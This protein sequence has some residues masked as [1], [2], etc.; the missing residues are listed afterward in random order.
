MPQ[1]LLIHISDREK[2]P[3]A[4]R[5]VQSLVESAPLEQLQVVIV[6]DI[7]AGGVCLTCHRTLRE[8]MEALV[9]A[10]HQIRVCAT[11]LQALNLRTAGLPEFVST[12]PNSLAEIPAR[13]AEGFQYLKL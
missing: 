1:K 10:G 12:V 7:F 11:S 13:L 9:E 4:I 3:V 5:L 8:Q 6:A 2:W